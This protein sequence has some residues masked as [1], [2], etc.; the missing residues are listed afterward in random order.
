MTGTDAGR[1]SCH[2]RNQSSAADVVVR[3]R[4]FSS[5]DAD[6]ARRPAARCMP[7]WISFAG[8]EV[9]GGRVAE[10]RTGQ[11]SEDRRATTSEMLN[12]LCVICTA[13]SDTGHRTVRCCGCSSWSSNE[14]LRYVLALRSVATTLD[15]RD[16]PWLF[17]AWHWST[18]D[19][20]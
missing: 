15:D 4:R 19:L 20:R 5:P 1:L 16:P 11:D 10:D 13:I 17:D 2:R 7:G 18:T 14:T 6:S 3:C 9:R 12:E 8:G